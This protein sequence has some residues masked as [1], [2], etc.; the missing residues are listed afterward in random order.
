MVVVVVVVAEQEKEGPPLPV[1]NLS[2][3][4]AAFQ[5]AVIALPLALFGKRGLPE[6]RNSSSSISAGERTQQQ[7]VSAPRFETA[8][9]PLK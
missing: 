7:P 3:T 9:L 2:D 1:K 5:G 6:S 8:I 4:L